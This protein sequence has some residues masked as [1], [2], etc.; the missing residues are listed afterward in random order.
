MTTTPSTIDQ[1]IHPRVQN[2]RTAHTKSNTARPPQRTT[3]AEKR[4]QARRADFEK[5]SPSARQG[6]RRPGSNK[7]G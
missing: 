5:L 4:L 1:S 3:K 2:G 6:R 7:K